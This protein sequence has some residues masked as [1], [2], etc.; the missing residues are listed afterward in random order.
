MINV[1]TCK[2]VHN[3]A[4]DIWHCNA[5]GVYSDESS[6]NSVGKYWCRGVQL[7]DKD[8][9]ATFTTIMPGW[10]TGR[11][12]HIH[13]KVRLKGDI[14]SG[15]YDGGTTTHIGQMFFPQHINSHIAT[16]TPYKNNT[17][18]RI[19]NSADRVYTQQNGS[20]CVLDLS[21][22]REEGLR[23]Q[24]DDGGPRLSGRGCSAA[25]AFEPAVERRL[26]EVD[27]G[28]GASQQLQRV[29]RD[30]V[31]VFGLDAELNGGR[32][33]DPHQTRWRQRRPPARQAAT[34]RALRR[35]ERPAR[36]R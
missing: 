31:R 2:P 8:G 22:Q 26:V 1:K 34:S 30:R 33:L 9:V 13:A 21:R 28:Q 16:L 36:C 23:R 5:L 7:T 29:A 18:S 19:T 20:S 17:Q 15:K 24:H 11:V 35:G 12:N 3:A 25:A 32:R 6:E 14:E 10:Y 27:I 4:L